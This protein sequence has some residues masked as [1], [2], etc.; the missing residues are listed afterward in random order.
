[1]TILLQKPLK[2]E[3]FV[4]NLGNKRNGYKNGWETKAEEM[5]KLE[6]YIRENL[7]VNKE[8]FVF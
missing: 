1:M 5:K 4:Y 2:F 6:K 8:S 7:A 3:N